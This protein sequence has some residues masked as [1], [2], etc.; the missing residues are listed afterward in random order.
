MEFS[1]VPYPLV[2]EIIE[3]SHRMYEKGLVVATDGN[4]SCRL[5]SQRIVITPS[6]K[7]KISLQ[8]QDLVIMNLKGEK[9]SGTGMPSGEY[10]M[11][12]MVYKERPDVNAVVHTHSPY[13]TGF[14]VA[15]IPLMQCVLPE[16]VLTLGGI[17]LTEYGTLYT[18]ELP[19]AIKKYIKDYNAFLLKNHGVLTI[20]EN[21][22][23]AYHR[24]EKVEHMAQVIY[25]AR[26]LGKVDILSRGQFQAL[27]K[28]REEIGLK[29]KLP[30]CETCDL[31]CG[32]K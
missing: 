5:D 26:S 3:I 16:V 30:E 21:L 31:S 15:G 27:M 20:G 28:L 19:Q 9:L 29:G 6:G 23:V 11:H 7:S 18:E 25:I 4:I 1:F 32:L 13:A 2:K 24:A 17:P 12:L 22:T 14:S 10:R 8:A